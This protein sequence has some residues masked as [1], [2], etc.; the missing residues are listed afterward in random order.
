MRQHH[1]LGKRGCSRGVLDQ[2]HIVRRHRLHA[3]LQLR[4][5]HRIARSQEVMPASRPRRT[6]LSQHPALAQA[7]QALARQAIGAVQR[8]FHLA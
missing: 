8:R 7:R 4:I 3:S 2:Q 6:P 1:A 5:V